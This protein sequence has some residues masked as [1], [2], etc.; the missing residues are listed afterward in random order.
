MKLSKIRG[1]SRYFQT[2]SKGLLSEP[3][4]LNNGDAMKFCLNLGTW[5]LGFC[6]PL[7]L[8]FGSPNG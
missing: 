2:S 1:K 6:F 3:A 7:S 8:V 5:H 4:E